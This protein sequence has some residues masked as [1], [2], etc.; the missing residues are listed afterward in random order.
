MDVRYI[1]IYIYIIKFEP[2]KSNM[3]VTSNVSPVCPD[4]FIPAS[5]TEKNNK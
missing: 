3:F 4:W 1:N 5:T 2:N